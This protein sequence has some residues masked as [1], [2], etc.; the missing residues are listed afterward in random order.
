MS[1]A[2]SGGVAGLRPRELDARRRVIPN[3]ELRVTTSVL[4]RVNG[5]RL[6]ILG[7][8]RAILMQLAHP[9]VAAGVAGHSAFHGSVTEGAARLFHTVSAMLA[10]TFGDQARRAAK[11]EHIR[12]IHRTVN[13]VLRED[14]GRFPAG[15]RYSAEDPA[16]LLWVHATLLE[17]SAEIYQ[18]TVAPLTPAELDVM[19]EE[20]APL[21][22]E[23][24]GDASTTPRTWAALRRY[25]EDMERSRVL[26]VTPAAREIGR[27][28]LAPRAVFWRAPLGRLHT[29]IGAGL[30]PPALREAYGFAWDDRR[31]AR[32]ERAIRFI[33]AARQVMPPQVARWRDARR[34]DVH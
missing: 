11:L 25:I 16:L 9:L 4:H 5:E 8:G 19:C 32:F 1:T 7:W 23:L 12:A 3:R 31:Q 2:R 21:V 33:R 18:R 28:V 27:A 26:A 6:V 34:A 13:G 29:L 24:G 14:A 17:S 30:L 20:S 10:L 15:T 22:A